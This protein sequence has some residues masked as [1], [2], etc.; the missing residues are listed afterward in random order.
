MCALCGT[1]Q[2]TNSMFCLDCFISSHCRSK[3]GVIPI[4]S[5]RQVN[6]GPKQWELAVHCPGQ[7]GGTRRGPATLLW[8]P[9]CPRL[10]LLRTP[11]ALSILTL[12][13][14]PS[15]T[16]PTSP[17]THTHPNAYELQDCALDLATCTIQDSIFGSRLSF[18][19]PVTFLVRL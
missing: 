16:A 11:Q 8:M 4:L 5:H 17:P 18:P 3:T 2:A 19:G 10:A 9:R 1:S 6:A 12:A 15:H 13:F 14:P 7:S